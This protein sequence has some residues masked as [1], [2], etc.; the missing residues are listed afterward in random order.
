MMMVMMTM[1]MMTLT[2]TMLELSPSV[3]TQREESVDLEALPGRPDRE[4]V[5]GEGGGPGVPQQDRP[6]AQPG[7]DSQ[8]VRHTPRLDGLGVQ[9]GLVESPHTG[10]Y[11]R[12]LRIGLCFKY[13]FQ[14]LIQLVADLLYS[15]CQ[16][17]QVR[18]SHL[19]PDISHLS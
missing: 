5:P 3:L 7:E 19:S 18:T 10:E 15:T 17:I 14:L 12:L 13:S 4:L 16:S 11:L 2:L 9:A 1:T 8:Q 6:A